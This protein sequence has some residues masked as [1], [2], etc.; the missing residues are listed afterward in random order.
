[1]IENSGLSPSPPKF[2]KRTL[3]LGQL[4]TG[5]KILAVHNEDES[6]GLAIENA[7]AA[8]VTQA[9]PLKVEI[10][11]PTDETVQEYVSGY[12]WINPA[13]GGFE[14]SAEIGLPQ[15]A[16]IRARDC[17]EVAGDTLKLSRTVK[18]AGDAP[19]GFLSAVTFESERGVSLASLKPFIPGMI[20]GN[21]EYITT[22]AIGGNAH[23]EAGVRQVRIREDRL[24]I[25]MAGLYFP[26]GSALMVSNACPD[27]GSNVRDAEEKIAANQI[28]EGCRVAALG[29][30][31]G[32]N[33]VTLGMWFPGTEGEVTYQWA[34]APDNQVRRWRGRYHPVREGFTQHYEVEFRF[35]GDESFDR[36]YN[37]AWRAAWDRLRPEVRPQDIELVR[38][39]VVAMVADRVVS[40]K[41]LSGIPTV[42]DATTG[43]EISTED[44]ILVA[45]RR[46]AVMG[47]LGRNTD[48]AYFLLD[49]A[50]HGVGP[51][52]ERY[53]RL[54]T[55]ILNSFAAIPMSP[56]AAEGFS[57][58]DGTPAA[59]TYR[60][61]PLIHLRAL[62]EGV[63]SMLKAWE[64]EKSLG[65]E[66]PHWLKWCVEFAD[67]LLTQQSPE[68]GFPRAWGMATGEVGLD[69]SKSSYTAI[70]YLVSLSRVTG[71]RTYLDAAAKAGE[72]CWAE[73]Q[74]L[75]HFV[76]G[77]LDNPNVVDKEAGTL[78]LE[79]YLSL[80]GAAGEKK[81][82]RRAE[83]AANFAETWM[84]CWD[85]PMPED[86]DAERLHWKEGVS[87]VGF[88]LISTGHSAVDA[89]M[90]F[91]VANYAKLY[92]YTRDPHYLEVAKILLHN[93]KQMLALP[94][95][96]YDLAGPGW[97][98]EG[99]NLTPPRGY[100]W[101][102]HWLPWVAASHLEGIVELRNFDPELYRR[103]A[104]GEP[105]R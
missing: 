51:Q 62:S 28:N 71:E 74:S 44:S 70:P 77:T 39:T 61:T 42:W 85:V 92:A 20:Y 91:D 33:E 100:G 94:G 3:P 101:H 103:L 66:H 23:Y 40:N 22:T 1:M 6:W 29:Y 68:G 80:Y 90:A 17:W 47:F 79:A 105:A 32:D 48:L 65:R 35:S 43:E 25:P 30:C 82:L 60:G 84:Y 55:S 53:A 95:R 67:W 56:P 75:G 87:S 27:A 63:K 18:V 31:E 38:R 21:S 9:R 83:T 24:P 50:A 45:N 36:F 89:Y 4:T 69:S 52:A 72:F 59:L 58:A 78:S 104:D 26:D 7:G 46:E 86:A 37:H 12:T 97:Q 102:R 5:A 13:G 64:L 16:C 98:Q 73:D 34:L 81:W 96:T 88:Q 49:E 2:A 10:F 99:W 19:Y 76:G 93:T 41:D 11:N 8:S 14:A 54:G 15:G 57:L